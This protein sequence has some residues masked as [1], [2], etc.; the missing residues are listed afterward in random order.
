MTPFQW[1]LLGLTGLILLWMLLK[2]RGD[3]TP[4]AAKKLVSDGALL[5]DVRTAAEFSMGHLPGAVNIPLD[6]LGSRLGKLEPKDRA[7][8][9]Y[10]L[11]GSRSA[12][13]K[14]ALKSAGFEKVANLGAMSRW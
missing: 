7:I 13:A 1:T 9:V 4:E 6:Q 10:C 5:L 14:G 3:V 2:R 8:V 12:A 11:S